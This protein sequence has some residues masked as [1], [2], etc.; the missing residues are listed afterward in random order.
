MAGF[1]SS[2]GRNICSFGQG[3]TRAGAVYHGASSE[4]ILGLRDWLGCGQ[5]RHEE[6][7]H[8]EAGEALPRQASAACGEVVR[9]QLPLC[10][11]LRRLH[12]IFLQTS[13]RREKGKE[14]TNRKNENVPM[15]L[16]YIS[17]LFRF[18]FFFIE[19]K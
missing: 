8:C 3:R 11:A 12:I 19:K 13:P 2:A 4:D 10:L 6:M 1:T 5:T 14:T 18:T 9:T 7:V 15:V 16:E 17:L